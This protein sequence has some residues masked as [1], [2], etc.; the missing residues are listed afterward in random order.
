MKELY[1]GAR[2]MSADGPEQ[3]AEMRN[4]VVRRAHQYLGGRAR[5][6]MHRDHLNDDQS[7]AALRARFL[8]GHERLA[9]QATTGKIGVMTGRE[10]PVRDLDA[11]DPKRGEKMREARHDGWQIGRTMRKKSS[12][13]EDMH[14]SGTLPRHYPMPCTKERP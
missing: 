11:F 5:R 7:R 4:A 2:A 12:T 1:E 8:I 10:D 9:R 13:P 14:V 3:R 6:L